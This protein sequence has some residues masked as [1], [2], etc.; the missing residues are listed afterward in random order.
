MV[1]DFEGKER[2]S[3]LSEEWEIWV[4]KKLK[5]QRQSLLIW[6]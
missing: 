4:Y 2:S 6:P 1:E 5:R 3:G